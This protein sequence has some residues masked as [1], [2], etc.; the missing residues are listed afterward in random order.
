MYLV[1]NEMIHLLL[2]E[3]MSTHLMIFKK[4]KTQ[5]LRNTSAVTAASRNKRSND[6]TFPPF[7][8]KMYHQ[9]RAELLGV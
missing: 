4:S 8:S 3:Y 2:L 5:Q 7:D 1:P 9:R 6:M